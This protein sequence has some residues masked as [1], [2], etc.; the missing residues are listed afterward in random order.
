MIPLCIKRKNSKSQWKQERIQTKL[1]VPQG[2]RTAEQ[3]EPRSLVPG[4]VSE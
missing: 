1:Q 3:Q 2:Q 4:G